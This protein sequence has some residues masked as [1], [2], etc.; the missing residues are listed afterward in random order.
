MDG[1][2]GAFCAGERSEHALNSTRF[3]VHFRVEAAGYPAAPPTDPYVINSVIRFLGNQS[4][5]TTLTHDFATL[6]TA[7][8]FDERFWRRVEDRLYKGP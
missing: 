4:G 7:L 3:T 1:K 5:D 8:R 2:C 6:Q